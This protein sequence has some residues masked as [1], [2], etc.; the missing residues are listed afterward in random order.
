MKVAIV[1]DDQRTIAR[2]FGR[3]R[4]FVIAEIEDCKV[5]KTSYRENDLTSHGRGGGEQHQG[6]HSHSRILDGLRGC[7]AVIAMGMGRRLY[8]DLHQAGIKAVITVESDVQQALQ[9]YIAGMLE[10]HP[11]RGC[12]G[13]D[14]HHGG[15][16]AE[17]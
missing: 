2:H 5:I 7:E 13:H 10:D 8:D 12:A 17:A 15:G 11:E 3:A 9:A 6:P 1:S 4:G 14:H 16:R